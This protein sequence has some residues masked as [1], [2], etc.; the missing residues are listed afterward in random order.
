[1]LN[2]LK[3]RMFTKSGTDQVKSRRGIRGRFSTVYR[4]D[5]RRKGAVA[6]GGNGCC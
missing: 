3:L 5:R 1:M 6:G 4:A 2:A